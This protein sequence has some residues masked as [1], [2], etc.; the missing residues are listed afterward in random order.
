MMQGNSVRFT[1]CSSL[2]GAQ[3]EEKRF[4]SVLLKYRKF[5]IQEVHNAKTG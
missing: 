1:Y 3:E 2:K 5:E 4:A